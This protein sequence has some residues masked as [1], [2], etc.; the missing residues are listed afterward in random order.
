MAGRV[1]EGI[2]GGFWGVE[3]GSAWV[4]ESIEV[5]LM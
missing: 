3:M 4:F 2:E 5:S 1:A